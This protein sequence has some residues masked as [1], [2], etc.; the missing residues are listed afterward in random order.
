[1]SMRDEASLRR[2]AEIGI[3]VYRRRDA[4]PRDTAAPS[5]VATQRPVQEPARMAA[6]GDARSPDN[7]DTGQ[8][9]DI[10]V[11]A[12]ATSKAAR[13][14][15]ADVLRTLRGAGFVCAH[16][17]AGDRSALTRAGAVVMLGQAQ[18]RAAGAV[19]SAQCQIAMG[20]VVST[21]ALAL[22]GNAGAKRAL[23]SELRRIMRRL[24]VRG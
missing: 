6:H 17:D 20:W 4:S 21:D 10:V 22:I 13:D 18:A 23:W 3:D 7:A 1:M 15:L 14:L 9:A 8:A 2:L 11:L 24:A 5:G 16:S 12:D 19:V